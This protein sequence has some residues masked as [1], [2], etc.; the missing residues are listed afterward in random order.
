MSKKKVKKCQECFQVLA[1]IGL[2]NVMM[3]LVIG[4]TPLISTHT[5]A[6]WACISCFITFVGI[7][8]GG[9]LLGKKDQK[10]PKFVKV[11]RKDIVE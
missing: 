11:D 3:A 6:T 1:I 9:C 7:L 5:F 8:F 10:V 4:Q 2:V